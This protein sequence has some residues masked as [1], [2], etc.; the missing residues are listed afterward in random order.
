MDLNVLCSSR[1]PSTTLHQA[2]VLALLHD[3]YEG[4]GPPERPRPLASE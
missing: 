4:R 2:F 3:A 1:D